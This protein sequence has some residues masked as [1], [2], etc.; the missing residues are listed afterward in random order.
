MKVAIVGGAG[1]RVPL[2]VRALAASDLGITEISLF[3][4]D[5]VRLDLIADLAGRMAEDVRITAHHEPE[6]AVDAAAFVIASIRAERAGS[7]P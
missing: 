2:L 7:A 1:V 3:D 4:I 5:R 6:P